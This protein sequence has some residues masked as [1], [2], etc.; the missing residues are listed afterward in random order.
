MYKI[1]VTMI[2]FVSE[3]LKTET[4]SKLPSLHSHC[5]NVILA[6]QH[7]KEWKCY[8]TPDYSTL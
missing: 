7:L 5:I 1:D 6:R 4:L 8:L 3:K 2:C